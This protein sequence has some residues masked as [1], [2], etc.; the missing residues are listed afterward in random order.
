M[1]EIEDNVEIPPRCGRSKSKYPWA[2]M[3]VGQSFFVPDGSQPSLSATAIGYSYRHPEMKFTTAKE[4]GGV[5]VWRI[6]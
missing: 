1:F 3:K 2:K 5:R 6:E 4:A